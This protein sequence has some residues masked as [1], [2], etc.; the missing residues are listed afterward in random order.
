MRRRHELTEARWKRIKPMLPPERGREG[1]PS[2]DNRRMVNAI[3]WVL[4]TGAPWR[5]LP[6]HYGCWQTAYSRF[7]RWSKR[8]VWA[9]LLAELAKDEDSA[10]YF[11]DAT[12]VRAHQDASGAEKKTAA[13]PSVNRAADRPRRFTF[14]SMP[15]GNQFICT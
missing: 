11:I 14:V 3:L 6:E 4:K 12:I 9:S 1:R 10:T 8:G 5:D 7:S 15:K 2:H 13:N